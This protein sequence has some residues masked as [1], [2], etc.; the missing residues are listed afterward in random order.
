MN[1]VTAPSS[2]WRTMRPAPSRSSV[3]T[4]TAPS[5]SSVTARMRPQS[6]RTHRRRNPGEVSNAAKPSASRSSSTVAPDTSVHVVTRPSGDSE[7]R[8]TPVPP[9][10]SASTS[11]GTSA[12]SSAE[13]RHGR[14]VGSRVDVRRAQVP[15]GTVVL[16]VDRSAELVGDR[17]QLVEG[18][19]PVRHRP[20]AG[21]EQLGDAPAPVVGVAHRHPAGVRRGDHPAA[22]VV[23]ERRGAP[24]RIGER[25][26]PSPRVVLERPRV[27]AHR[28]RR[29]VAAHVV[30]VALLAPCGRHPPH[31]APV[32][33]V[34]ELPPAG[35]AVDTGHPPGR[36]VAVLDPLA[37]LG[38]RGDA[39]GRGV[40]DVLGPAVGRRGGRQQALGGVGRLVLAGR[41]A[42]ATD[43]VDQ[44]ALELP[45]LAG[46]V[47][48][49][50]PLAERVVLGLGL[51]P[52]R[53]GQLDDAP[54]LVAIDRPPAAV[55]VDRRLAAELVA[56]EPDRVTVGEP[57]ARR[58]AAR[59]RTRSRSPRRRR[60]RPGAAGRRRRTRG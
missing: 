37:A 29:R 59:R 19:V 45:A 55:D 1:W 54:R 16:G 40:A 51:D 2:S 3:V 33:V 34:L 22:L 8:T 32:G 15:A 11:A 35:A 60:R 5:T 49:A 47:G 25:A 7:R 31:H 12:P 18:V 42:E 52:G 23:G 50:R 36:V 26:E 38:D 14:P 30:A 39:P 21:I 13:P 41:R 44:S 20:A 24:G 56:L 53:V 58:R 46:G 28:D 27:R 9:A 6:S 57:D 48:D 17:R 4:C 43:A 10:T